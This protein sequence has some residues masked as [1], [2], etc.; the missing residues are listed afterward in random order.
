M[1]RTE[2]TNHASNLF[3][4][5]P[6]GTTVEQEW[7]NAVQGELAYVIEQAGLTLKTAST[8]TRQQLQEALL[9]HIGDARKQVYET[10]ATAK[11]SGIVTILSSATEICTIDLGTVTLG[12]VFLIQ[13]LISATKGGTAGIGRVMIGRKS[14]T[15]YPRT[16]DTFET[17]VMEQYQIASEPRSRSLRPILIMWIILLGSKADSA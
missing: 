4:D 13:G 12:D 1:H 3:T 17:H 6:P 14:G 10:I 5:G 16:Y 8:E 11:N 9:L 2:G 15:G 7:L